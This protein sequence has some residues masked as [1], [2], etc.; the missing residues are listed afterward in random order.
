MEQP[1]VVDVRTGFCD[2]RFETCL[3]GHVFGRVFEFADYDDVGRRLICLPPDDGQGCFEISALH[4]S[5]ENADPGRGQQVFCCLAFRRPRSWGIDHARRHCGALERT[6]Q[7]QLPRISRSGRELKV[8]ELSGGVGGARLARG[9]SQLPDV[10]LTV[11]VNV[12]DDDRVHGLHISP[13]LDTVIYTLAGVEGPHGWGRRD[14]SFNVNEELIRFGVDNTFQLGDRDLALNLY[15]TRRLGMGDPLSAITRDIASAFEV[16]AALIPSTDDRLATEIRVPDD[17]WISFQEYFVFRS[18]QDRVDEIR[19]TGAPEATPAPGVIDAVGQA[20]MVII[21][22]SNPP[23]SIWP[24]LAVQ[25]IEDAVREHPK[26]VALSPLIRRKALKGPADRVMESLGL[27]QGTRGI[28]EAYKGIIDFL[29]IHHDDADEAQGVDEV[30]VVT[31]ET[32]IKDAEA[33]RKLARTMV[34]L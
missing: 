6:E 15:R 7:Y 16:G 18:H 3:H 17:G 32:I 9:L 8:L 10:D 24:I 30:K 4:V 23:L 29:V 13:D 28:V 20:D 33:A 5:D 12:G 26:V 31:A 1:Q 25:E 19:Y 22:P 14:D 2:G 34:R 21:G 27:P 11:V